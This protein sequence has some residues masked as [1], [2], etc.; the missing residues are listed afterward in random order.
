MLTASKELKAGQELPSKRE[1]FCYTARM[2]RDLVIAQG[3]TF[4]VTV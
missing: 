3:L 2:L 4:F 1:G